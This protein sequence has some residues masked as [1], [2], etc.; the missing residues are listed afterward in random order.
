M[1]FKHSKE[2]ENLKGFERKFY[3]AIV[4]LATVLC[5]GGKAKP[6]EVSFS[7]TEDETRSLVVTATV[8]TRGLEVGGG[9]MESYAKVIAKHFP[10]LFSP[11]HYRPYTSVEAF[12]KS[13]KQID[14]IG[15][16]KDG[17]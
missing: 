9:Y 17:I 12:L 3:D 1:S 10:A 14:I 11:A 6:D 15:V 5:D 4:E 2:S 13:G 8:K 7:Y 16:Y